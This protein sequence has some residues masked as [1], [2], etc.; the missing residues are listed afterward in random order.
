MTPN[1]HS[2]PKGPPSSPN[3]MAEDLCKPWRQKTSHDSI[4]QHTCR[5]TEFQEINYRLAHIYASLVPCSDLLRHRLPDLILRH[6]VE[7]GH[8]AS[9][10]IDGNKLE[11]LHWLLL[12]AQVHSL[13]NRVSLGVCL[14]GGRMQLKSLGR[15]LETHHACL[16]RKKLL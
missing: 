16:K 2:P 4:L 3:E 12:V 1:S 5:R 10:A 11:T 15:P 13:G 6:S 14:S 8:I 7:Y 9:L